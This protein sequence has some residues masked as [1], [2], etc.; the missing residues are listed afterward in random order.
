M[1]LF[2]PGVFVVTLVRWR[3]S[4]DNA[5]CRAKQRWALLASNP[6]RDSPADGAPR[7]PVPRAAATARGLLPRPRTPELCL[8]KRTV[9]APTRS[10]LLPDLDPSW[11]HGLGRPPPGSGRCGLAASTGGFTNP[12]GIPRLPSIRVRSLAE[13]HLLPAPDG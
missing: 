6:P 11:P 8:P 4:R 10:P 5:W 3:A 2:S 1:A 9:T 13:H 7:A 12:C